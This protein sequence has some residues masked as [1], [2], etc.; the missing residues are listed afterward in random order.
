[1]TAATPLE[2]GS[3]GLDHT[4]STELWVLFGQASLVVSLWFAFGTMVFSDTLVTLVV[5]AFAGA[6]IMLSPSGTAGRI[7]LTWPV[8]VYLWWWLVSLLWTNNIYGWQLRTMQ[9]MPAVVV[10]MVVA[11]ML[12]TRHLLRG[13]VFLFT[14]MILYQLVPMV[15]SYST[16]SVGIDPLSGAILPGWRGS[17]GHKNGMAPAVALGILVVLLFA[18]PGWLRRVTLLWGTVLVAMSLSATGLAGFLT[19]VTGVGWYRIYRRREGRTSTAFLV[20]SIALGAMVA[21]G[22][23]L[24]FPW[25]IGLYG[26]DVTLSG[27]TKIWAAVWARVADQPINGRGIGGAFVSFGEQPTVGMVREVG[28]FFTHSHN[29]LLDLA[30]TLGF[31]G[32]GLWLIIVATTI[33]LGA[34]LQ[35]ARPDIGQLLLLFPLVLIVVNVSEVAVYG[36]WFS[37]LVI[38]RVLAVRANLDLKQAD[39]ARREAERRAPLRPRPQLGVV[40]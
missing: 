15:L 3:I 4:S 31:V 20:A 26:K 28:F 16:A 34:R 14:A 23:A 22:T 39:E 33:G 32:A 11:S 6:M 13:L 12:P 7:V 9:T 35:Q 30:L 36:S 38:C 18:K 27:R 1:M 5:F 37:M 29:G 25:L 17:F 19:V 8:L 24:L 40:R 2:Q 10:S 21:A